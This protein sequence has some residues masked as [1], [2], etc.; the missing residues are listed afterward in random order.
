MRMQMQM[1]V[2]VLLPMRCC[3]DIQGI[4]QMLFRQMLKWNAFATS[5]F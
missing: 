3:G 2:F 1:Y 4:H 5:L